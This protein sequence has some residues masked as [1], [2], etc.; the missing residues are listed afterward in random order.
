MALTRS[1][2][3]AV[4]SEDNNEVLTIDDYTQS[5][6]DAHEDDVV[7]SFCRSFIFL[8]ELDGP[9]N[10]NFD[11]LPRLPEIFQFPCAQFITKCIEKD[12]ILRIH[13]DPIKEKLE[14]EKNNYTAFI[15]F[16]FA[17][18]ARKAYVP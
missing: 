6:K 7:D 4:F 16:L 10:D 9:F 17:I 11:V 8:A 15:Y 13:L 5:I 18:F 14:T 12:F 3:V 2:S 1:E